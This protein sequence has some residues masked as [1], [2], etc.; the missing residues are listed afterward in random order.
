M[1]FNVPQFAEYLAHARGAVGGSEGVETPSVQSGA[2]ILGDR[3]RAMQKA[4]GRKSFPLSE[5]L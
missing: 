3:V 2:D 1:Q 5:V 4:T